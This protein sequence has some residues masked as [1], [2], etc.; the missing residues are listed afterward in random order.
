MESFL[1]QLKELDPFWAYLLLFISAVVENIFP[2]IPGDTVTVIGAYLVGRGLLNYWGVFISTTLGSSMGFMGIF[3]IAYLLKLKRILEYIPQ[4]VSPKK[5]QKAE[6]WIHNYGYWVILLNRFLSGAR[7][8]I[9]VIAGLS[10]MKP[11]IVLIAAT[12]SC[13]IWNGLLIYFGSLIGKNWEEIIAFLKVYNR[14]VIG[15][16]ITALVILFFV[17]RYRKKRKATT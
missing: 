13:A 14:F 1:I 7:S 15:T 2:P 9:S 4:K 17:R 5:I 3:W 12:I 10:K 16:L 6:K 11:F 8:V